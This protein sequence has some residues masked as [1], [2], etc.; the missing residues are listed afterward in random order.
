MSGRDDRRE[1]WTDPSQTESEEV[2]RPRRRGPEAWAASPGFRRLTVAWFFSNLADSALFLMSAVWVKDLTGSDVAAAMVFAMMG[3]PALAAPFLGQIADRYS[4]RQVL[5]V[6]NAV[7]ALTV[8][9]LLLVQGAA[10][11]WLIYVII[12]LYATVGYLTSAAQA[13]LVRDL[14]PDEHLAS[15]NATLSTID[16]G[17]RLLSPLLGTGIYVWLGPHAVVLLTVASFALAAGLLARMQVREATPESAAERG[18]YY[19][20]VT[21]GIR[22]L[23]ATPPLGMMIAIAA[24]A[25]GAAGLANVSIFPAL[26]HGM[27]LQASTLGLFSA[28]QGVGAV[29]GG[30]TAAWAIK[31]AGEQRTFAV[32]LAVLGVG[33]LPLAGGSPALLALGLTLVG[34]SVVWVVVSV[35][36]LRQR[37][38]PPRLQGRTMAATSIAINL[39]QTLVTLIGAAAIGFIDYRVLVLATSITI[40][41]AA[42][43][44]AARAGRP[45]AALGE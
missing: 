44:M 35:V 3:L 17:L 22:H 8:A 6:A 19:A 43:V 20:E 29:L 40:I 24:L 30:L 16:K 14:L 21:A 41:V 13:G 28:A 39:P 15:G 34:W 9:T 18:S 25:F 32:G 5:V 4:R 36:T 31:R 37:L 27:G 45:V 2:V 12:L 11:V 1:A 42:S 26:E 23:A 33:V 7:I 38:T 10:D